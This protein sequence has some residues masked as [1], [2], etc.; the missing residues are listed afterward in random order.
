MSNATALESGNKQIIQNELFKVYKY[1]Y[2][3]PYISKTNDWKFKIETI[4]IP[5]YKRP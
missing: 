1:L 2:E 3:P 5:I 4:L